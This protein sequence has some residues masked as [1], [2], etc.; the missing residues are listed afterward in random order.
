MDGLHI[1]LDKSP[2]L[3]FIA[4]MFC[5]AI[6]MFINIIIHSSVYGGHPRNIDYKVWTEKQSDQVILKITEPEWRVC[7]A[8]QT[9]NGIFASLTPGSKWPFQPVRVV[10]P[11]TG[12]YMCGWIKPFG[13]FGKK[14]ATLDYA[15]NV[16]VY[17]GTT[18]ELVSLY[19]NDPYTKLKSEEKVKEG[20]SKLRESLGLMSSAGK[21]RGFLWLHEQLYF[22]IFVLDDQTKLSFY[23]FDGLFYNIEGLVVPIVYDWGATLVHEILHVFGAGIG[24][25]HYP[26]MDCGGGEEALHFLSSHNPENLTRRSDF[27]PAVP[28][29][30][31]QGVSK[32]MRKCYASSPSH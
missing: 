11:L 29:E 27:C 8:A 20:V 5:D 19:L 32:A 7:I 14:M 30:F 16:P 23:D 13:I 31:L 26:R 22:R 17:N 24:A 4:Q 2:G 28:D 3:L 9:V 10:D 25:E 15:A 18:E 1:S 21:R 12:K 6:P